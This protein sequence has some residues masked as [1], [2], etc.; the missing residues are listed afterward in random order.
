MH[1]EGAGD[2]LVADA[3]AFDRHRAVCGTVIVLEILRDRRLDLVL[4]LLVLVAIVGKGDR[5]HDREHG[6][7]QQSAS[8]EFPYFARFPSP[9]LQRSAD[10]ND[11]PGTPQRLLAGRASQGRG[12]G[13][14]WRKRNGTGRSLDDNTV[15]SAVS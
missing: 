6:G 12:D 5:G 15:R 13:L 3:V 4:V 2:G 10:D 9:L 11:G 8:H 1:D 7:Q 14:Y